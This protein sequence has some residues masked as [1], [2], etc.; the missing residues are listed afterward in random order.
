LKRTKELGVAHF[1]VDACNAHAK[2]NIEKLKATIE[3]TIVHVCM[4]KA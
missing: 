4:E 2:N 3:E 1:T